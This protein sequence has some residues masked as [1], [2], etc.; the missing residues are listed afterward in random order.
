MDKITH[1]R[2]N[3]NHFYYFYVTATLG[4]IKATSEKLHVSQPTVSDQ[5][6]LLE[7]FLDCQ[8]FERRNRALFLTK[9]GEMAFKTATELFDR[10]YEL[11][12]RLRR[13]ERLPKKSLDIGLTPHMVQYFDYKKVLPFFNNQSM[14]LSF[15]EDERH[16]LL[17]QLEEENI[18]IL[19]SSSKEGIT[20]NMS[21]FK[22]GTNKTFV[23]AHSQFRKLKKDFPASLEELPH[24]TY[25]RNS[26]MRAEV[27]LFFTSRGLSPKIIGESDDFDLMELI[28][29]NGLGF[30]VVSEV[31][32]NRI[33]SH[34]NAIVLG[35]MTELQTSV[36]AITKKGNL[37]PE[38]EVMK[39][40]IKT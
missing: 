21:A 1:D 32:M 9:E 25:S 40:G 35:E 29:L 19:I 14:T 2:L 17:A 24:F 12:T 26:P 39:K 31:G 30:C 5:I 8:L 36:W 20:R 37:I 15:T 23:I 3:F 4:S 27:D 10:A 33:C 11:T 18:D 38:L 22:L 34:K 28:T 6:K 13:K 7:E 16:L